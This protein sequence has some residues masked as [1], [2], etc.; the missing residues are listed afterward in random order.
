MKPHPNEVFRT[1]QLTNYVNRFKNIAFFCLYIISRPKLLLLIF[2]KIYLPVYVQYEWLKKF[3]IGT[4]V[5]IGA[6]QGTVTYALAALCPDADIYAFE[7]I[8]YV[9]DMMKQK[10]KSLH[11]VTVI[12]KALGNRNGK[13]LF[14]VNKHSPSSS[15]LPLSPLDKKIIPVY[16]KKTTVQAI[17]LDTYFKNKIVKQPI[18]IKIDVQGAENIVFEGGKDFLNKTS[19]I[20]VET[21]FET[22]YKNQCLFG[23]I[24]RM[25]IRSGFVYHGSIT[26]S[27][28]YPVFSISYFE[29]SFFI[30]KSIV[31]F[32]L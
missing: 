21:G 28:F 16:T 32:I 19:V 25:L 18:F 7:P 5:D 10:V 15:M 13:I 27:N 24:Y 11:N 3:N 22:V 2:K 6:N 29:N 30:K 31:R 8:K 12:N 4:I 1:N 17:T 23:D 20:H 14:Y 26:D 9:C